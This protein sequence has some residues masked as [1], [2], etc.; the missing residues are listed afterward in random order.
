M[1]HGLYLKV[2]FILVF[3]TTLFFFPLLVYHQFRS[4]DWFFLLTTR[5]VIEQQRHWCK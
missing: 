1:R 2:L 4:R 3:S 5:K